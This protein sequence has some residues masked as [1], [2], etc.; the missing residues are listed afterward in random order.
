MFQSTRPHGGATTQP[1]LMLAVCGFQSTRPARGAT[2][3]RPQRI[4]AWFWFQ[5][6]RPHGRAT[7][8]RE[9]ILRHGCFNPRARAAQRGKWPFLTADWNRLFQSTRPRM[10]RD[11][12]FLDIAARG[13][14]PRA[15]VGRDFQARMSVT[16]IVSIHAP[17]RGATRIVAKRRC[18][19]PRARMGRDRWPDRALPGVSI[20]APAWGATM[21]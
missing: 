15:R 2:E 6:T 13:F 19:N 8:H 21:D 1:C 7:A 10:G 12:L 11:A 9:S 17:T 3:D 14:N 5:S 20:H 16:A 4:Q 18:F